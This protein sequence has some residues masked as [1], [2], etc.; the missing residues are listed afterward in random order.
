MQIFHSFP[1][2]LQY[3]VRL[4]PDS[5]KVAAVFLGQYVVRLPPDSR[6]VAAVFL[7][8]YVVD[9]PPDSP[10]RAKFRGQFAPLRRQFAPLRELSP[11]LSQE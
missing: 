1:G 4:P 5:R 3:V 6:K 8:Q 11:G 9:L 2:L 7:G 10:L